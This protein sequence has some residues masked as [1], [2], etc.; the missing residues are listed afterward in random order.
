MGSNKIM[1]VEKTLELEAKTWLISDPKEFFDKKQRETIRYPLLKKQMGLNYLD[2]ADMVVYDVGA[3][4]FGGVSSV[5]NAREIY[6]IDPLKDEYAKIANVDSYIK[7]KAEEMDYS[8]ADLVI[9][10]NSIDHFEN[11]EKFF[12][13]L[14]ET[15]KSG[16]Y[17]AHLHA[18]NNALTHP[19][20]AHKFN[21][22]PETVSKNLTDY[23]KCWEL[24]YQNDGLV[25]GWL[26]QPAFAQ[27]WRKVT[28]YKNNSSNEGWFI[29][30]PNSLLKELDINELKKKW[31]GLTG[32][33]SE[34]KKTE[35]ETKIIFNQEKPIK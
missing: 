33:E 31:E 25:Y 34:I 27:L 14:T 19:H 13:R 32:F 6:R 26:K 23:E 21:V 17:F 3:G 12:K 35:H 2:T 20:E 5:I 9:A 11:P 30:Y 28:G 15:M 8:K 1:T 10:T 22:N 18:I 29:R 24:D 7:M 4:P 16:G